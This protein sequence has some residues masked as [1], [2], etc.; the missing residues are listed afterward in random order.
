[1][2]EVGHLVYNERS[3][4]GARE[5][6][7]K[8]PSVPERGPEGQGLQRETGDT[9]TVRLCRREAVGCMVHEYQP[10]PK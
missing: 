2:T 4:T 8:M 10:R 3:I 9:G 1:M 6:C 5:F 7:S